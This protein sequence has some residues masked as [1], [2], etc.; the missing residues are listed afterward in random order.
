MHVSFEIMVL[1]AEK[2]V[3]VIIN[4]KAN[5]FFNGHITLD[6][7]LFIYRHT[8]HIRIILGLSL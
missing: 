2:I 3:E 5:L 8:D 6:D 1:V 7:L 4:I